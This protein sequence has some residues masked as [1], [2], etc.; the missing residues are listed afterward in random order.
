MKILFTTF[1]KFGFGTNIRAV[2][3]A[4]EFCQLGHD[5]TVMFASYDKNFNIKALVHSDI[6]GF[7]GSFIF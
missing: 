2:L 1:N 5:V 6:W 3:L 7:H 4:S